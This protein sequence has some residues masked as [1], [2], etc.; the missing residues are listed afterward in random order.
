MGGKVNNKFSNLPIGW[1]VKKLKDVAINCGDYGANAPALPYK[2]GDVRYIR[3]TDIDD[4]GHLISEDK[5]SLDE[6]IAQNYLLKDND[7]LFARTGDTVGKSLLYKSYMGRAAYAGYLIRFTLDEKLI[8][9]EYFDAIAKSDIFEA[10]KISMKRIGAK[11]NIN[12][13]EYGIFRFPMP[14]NLDE[15]KGIAKLF[16]KVDEAIASVQNS[17][18]AAERLKKSLM[19]N[20]LT[21]KMK[22]DGTFRTPDEFYIDEKFGKVPVGWEVERVDALF[23][24]YPTASYSRSML[25]DNGDCK[26]IHYGDIHTRF[27]TFLDISKESLPYINKDMVKKFVYL[28]NGDIIISDTSEDYEGVG[29]LVE[30]VNLGDSKVI[31]GLHTLL[32]RPKTDDLINGFKGY[33]FN[34]ERV[35]LEFLKYVTGIKVYSISKNSLANVL[36]PIPT[37]QEQE[38]IKN[39]LDAV[40]NDI[41]SSKTKIIKLEQLKKSLMQNLLTGKVRVTYA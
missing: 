34:E 13:R 12:S 32:L 38:S 26:Y 19:Q 10:F 28:E 24:F 11:P 16:T 22:P 35:R 4:Y 18:A 33:L 41:S 15:Q 3:I 2:T 17:I 5:A 30:I 36:L 6:T 23:D 20:L 37:K 39:K 21:G 27:H 8:L 40:N 25:S 7:I 29:K 31:S 9:P 1:E 14:L